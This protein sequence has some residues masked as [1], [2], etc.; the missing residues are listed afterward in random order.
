MHDAVLLNHHLSPATPA[1]RPP[2][3]LPAPGQVFGEEPSPSPL[4]LPGGRDCVLELFSFAKSYHREWR[5]RTSSRSGD[6]PV[7]PIQPKG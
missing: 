3:R 5:G 4:C 1:C 2:P 6:E 7:C